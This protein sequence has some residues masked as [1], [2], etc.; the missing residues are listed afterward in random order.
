VYDAGA[1]AG[2]FFIAME[3]VSG[4][5]LR[6]WLDVER[7]WRA[8]VAV[9]LAAGRGLAAAHAIGL[10]HRD[11]KPDNVLVSD[12]GAVRVTDFGLARSASERRPSSQTDA[13]QL[14]LTRHDAMMGTPGYF[15]PELL[16][17]ASA[18]T[19]ASDQFSFCAALYEALYGGVPFPG[20]NLVDQAVRAKEVTLEPPPG[21]GVPRWLFALVQRGLAS[22]PA[23]RF[24]SLDALLGAL[25]DDPTRRT[26]ARAGA[27][28]AAAA[29]LVAGG[30][31][32]YA[33]LTACSG[34]EREV[35][36]A[37]NEAL[38]RRG[39]AAFAATQRP[40]AAAAW[41]R[42]KE[43]LDRYAQG[44]VAARESACAAK[45]EAR[46]ECLEQLRDELASVTE[47]FA[48][49]D[50]TV[51]A[52]AGGAVA[53]LP[54]LASCDNPHSR[55]SGGPDVKALRSSLARARALLLT[56]Q[57][58]AA[59]DAAR[60]LYERAQALQAPALVAKTALVLGASLQ[61]VQNH[62]CLQVFETGAAAAA[63][64][65]DDE[66]LVLLLAQQ[67]T[68]RGMT[69]AKPGEA[70]ALV[71]LATG[72]ASKI[73]DRHRAI[74][75]L[76]AARGVVEWQDRKLN[77]ALVLQRQAL[78]Q[79][80]LDPGEDSLDVARGRYHLGWTLMELGQLDDAKLALEPSI[81]ALQQ[82]YGEQSPALF[83]AWNALAGVAHERGDYETA[84]RYSR[85]TL[86]LGKALRYEDV[87]LAPMMVNLAQSLAQGG[88][89]QEAQQLIERGLAL[90][91]LDTQRPH[92][93]SPALTI[94]GVVAYEQGDFAG[95]IAANTEAIEVGR[96]HFGERHPRLIEPLTELARAQLMAGDL[97]AA[98]TN[99][100]AAL[101]IAATEADTTAPQ[102]GQ[103][104][105]ILG[106]ARLAAGR[107]REA[108]EPLSRALE[109]FSGL[110]GY[111]ADEVGTVRLALAEAQWQ[112]GARDE[113]R[114]T[115]TAAAAELAR[116][117]KKGARA[118]ADDWLMKHAVDSS[119]TQ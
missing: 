49:A 102:R 111:N 95:A 71:P 30:A 93:R 67:M 20:D 55:S 1:W 88:H 14:Q 74:G 37:W 7:P 115:A 75:R 106:R 2:G 19:A 53:E 73:P 107:A 6:R 92:R 110:Q 103:L 108:L 101:G 78:D 65:G 48:T 80:L 113:A 34:F 62:E 76:L 11:F 109:Q 69:L 94:R 52:A 31:L 98:R 83:D 85:L 70:R 117:F 42:A 27:V 25:A 87:A 96:R 38:A 43:R 86:E 57:H 24:P 9:F 18:V 61:Q 50:A 10:V 29:V 58:Q 91:A 46:I 13:L 41:V 16:H 99:S 33:R 89:F 97:A 59:V 72:V 5:T 35:A 28:A 45:Q 21:S 23:H 4:M 114:R 26:R 100:E 51:V 104:L 17:D 63:A 15:A 119:R 22:D 116:S 112:T 84:V 60:P 64:A 54:A 77:E 32:A 66:T 36:P 81:A 90:L 3:L 118:P 68:Q 56:G 12:R 39:E 82:I 47:E 105:G 44:W 8:V 40:F 79:F